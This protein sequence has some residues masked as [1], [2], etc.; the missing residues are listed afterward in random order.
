MRWSLTGRRDT[1]SGKEGGWLPCGQSSS[2]SSS[3]CLSRAKPNCHRVL[4]VPWAHKRTCQILKASRHPARMAAE[5]WTGNYYQEPILISVKNLEKS[6]REEASML[7]YSVS[8]LYLYSLGQ[9]RWASG[10]WLSLYCWAKWALP[11]PRPSVPQ[12]QG[13]DM[14]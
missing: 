11:P 10:T 13:S 9:G 14:G 5:N 4:H 3:S 2:E 7:G 6:M 12:H 8:Q 1:G